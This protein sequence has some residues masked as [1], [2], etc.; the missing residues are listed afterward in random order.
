MNDLD[1]LICDFLEWLSREDRTYADVM[2]TW[3]SSC[4][5][6]T[7]WEDTM[8]RGLVARFP[9][10]G[11]ETII[12][13]TDAGQTFLRSQRP[14]LLKLAELRRP[15]SGPLKAQIVR[16]LQALSLVK[17]R[18]MKIN[19]GFTRFADAISRLAGK[20][21]TFLVSVA[22]IVVG[23]SQGRFFI[24]PT[25][26]SSSSTPE[27]RSSPSS[28]FSLFKTRRT[29]MGRPFRRN[30]TNSYGQARRRTSS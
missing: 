10:L 8:D 12:A 15:Q 29:A 28:W 14:A 2:D 3:R 22:V 24:I 11:E 18:S 19:R 7:V 13:I 20:P 26:G 21:L 6:L 30:S 16:V 23:P 9:R 5:R 27:R 4:P 17:G 25:P 1:S